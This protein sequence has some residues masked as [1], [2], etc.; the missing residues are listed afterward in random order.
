MFKR[1]NFVKIAVCPKCASLYN[2]EKCTRKVG[3]QIVSNICSKKPFKK[4][5]EC[6]ASLAKKVI[7]SYG[8]VSF[9]P[10][11]L[12]CYNSVI[13]QV[14]GLL[15]RPG[16]PE[17]CEQWREREVKENIFADFCDGGIWKD[18]LQY[19]GEDF[20]AVP[21]N[22]AFAINVDWFQPFKR[23]SDRSVGVIYLVLLNLP[24]EQRFRWE[25]II[26]AGIIP[27][28]S[29]EPK[30]LNTFLAPI[31]D[32][33][34][35]LWK[36]VKLSTSSCNTC[37]TYRG[38]LLL[39]AADLP[40]RRKLCGFKG[41][42]AHRGCSKCFKYFPGSFKDKTDYSGFDRDT[43]PPRHISSRRK[44]AEMVRKASTQTQ[45]EHLA[46]KYGVYYS[47]LLQLEYFDAVKFTA[48]DPMHNLFL[49]T[50]KHVFKLWTKKNLLTKKDL[51]V[52]EEHIHSFDVGTGFGCLPHRMVSNYGGYTAS[53]W[54]NWTLVY[55]MYCL[56][57]LLPVSHLRC[58][59]TFVL[60]CQYLSSP[61]ASKVDILK[62]DMLFVKFGER[63]ERLY[64]K[65][66]V[67]PN[68]HLHCHLK[69]CI[70][71]SGPV[72]AFWC[73]SFERFNG[74]L[75]SMQVNGRSVEVQLMRKLLAGRFVWD[76]KFPTEFKDTFM[77]FFTQESSDPAESL[78]VKNATALFNSACCLNLG[79]FQWS[80]LTHVTL[81]RSF[82]HF[83][84]DPDELRLLL[85][86]YKTLYPH[87][88]IELPFLSRVARKYSNIMLGSEKF[89]SKM[90]C[91]NL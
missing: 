85:H 88:T 56:Q 4:G 8:K 6:G 33:L 30:S 34:Q 72:H 89:G 12:Y 41:Y 60:A 52:L 38:A 11:K 67:T 16:V 43:W 23:R 24:R 5:K 19:K 1:D 39:A 90:D 48:I 69:E 91:R 28:M 74:I 31:V 83:A 50:A 61:V 15:K 40:A 64:G 55:S 49:G 86:C 13:D 47:S 42:A 79:D 76:A 46:T 70:A 77:P 17:M 71:D 18:F 59:Q 45:K 27:E 53:Q 25:N 20:L 9:F 84:L 36:G 14:E 26:V 54:K 81:P 66:S 82:K 21:R 80:N 7:L 65:K 22:L 3:G 35:A 29:K 78:I 51:K 62:A 10:H 44:H 75:G 68:M 37:L 87:E 57:G 73:F 63:F 2:L 58:W 32:E